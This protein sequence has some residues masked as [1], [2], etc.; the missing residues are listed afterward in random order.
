M[1]GVCSTLAQSFLWVVVGQAPAGHKC[2]SRLERSRLRQAQLSRKSERCQGTT[3]RTHRPCCAYAGQLAIRRYGTATRLGVK[4]SDRAATL[5]SCSE[6]ALHARLRQQLEEGVALDD[7]GSKW[8][9]DDV[10]PMSEC[11][12]H[13]AWAAQLAYTTAA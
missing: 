2:T 9:E 3:L 12:L 8:Y 1:S 4:L 10:V 11:S 5:R 13:D 6:H 7:N